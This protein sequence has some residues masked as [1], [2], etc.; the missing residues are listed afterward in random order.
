MSTKYPAGLKWLK[1][2][3]YVTEATAQSMEKYLDKLPFDSAMEIYEKWRGQLMQRVKRSAAAP[4]DLS[5]NPN[6]EGD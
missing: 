3:N 2:R 6:K 4:N 5:S 1:Q